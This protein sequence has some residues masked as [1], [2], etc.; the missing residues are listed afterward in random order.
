MDVFAT[1]TSCGT[2]KKKCSTCRN[3]CHEVQRGHLLL[4]SN[5]ISKILNKTDFHRHADVL[6]RTVFITLV[7]FTVYFFLAFLWSLEICAEE[8]S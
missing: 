5:L 7:I 4:I 1:R 3:H 6:V 8:E 2:K